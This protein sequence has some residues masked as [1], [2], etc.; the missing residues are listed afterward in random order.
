VSCRACNGASLSW[1]HYLEFMHMLT[2]L[3]LSNSCTMETK[4]RMVCVK[5]KL[6]ELCVSL[7]LTVHAQ[8]KS[9]QYPA[10]QEFPLVQCA[11]VD[12]SYIWTRTYPWAGPTPHCR[13]TL[14]QLLELITKKCAMAT[15]LT[16]L[17]LLE[18]WIYR[19]IDRLGMINNRSCLLLHSLAR[20]IE[21]RWPERRLSAL[22]A[23]RRSFNYGQRLYSSSCTRPY[24]FDQSWAL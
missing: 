11:C 16:V 21:A 14:Q 10:C 5:K 19:T 24:S 9:K 8:R 13:P 6:D 7:V 22:S 4:V 20:S 2:K 18:H 23:S 1:S 17:A 3:M 15:T 12:E